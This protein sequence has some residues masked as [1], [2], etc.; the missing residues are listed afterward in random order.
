MTQIS[1]EAGQV[2]QRFDSAQTDLGATKR[3]LFSAI[4]LMVLALAIAF[5]VAHTF[6]PGLVSFDSWRQYAQVIKQD[7]LND[8]HPVIMVYVWRFLMEVIG[9]PGV[10]LGFHQLLYW[11]G[12]AALACLTFRTGWTRLAVFL[13]IGFC[14]PLFILTLHVWKDVG[15]LVGLLWASVGLLAFARAQGRRRCERISIAVALAGMFYATAVR[16]NGFAP[17]IFLSAALAALM[18]VPNVRSFRRGM[19]LGAAMLALAAA[20]QSMAMTA[21]NADAKKVYALGTLMV[22]DMVEISLD[23]Q[24]DLVPPYLSRTVQSDF[25]GE[26]EKVRSREANYKSF[27]IV[28][29]YPPAEYETQLTADWFA[30]VRKYPGSYLRHRLHVIGVLLGLQPGPI[31]YPFHRGIDENPVGL[32]FKYM[33]DAE[34]S[35]WIARF[36]R[37]SKSLLYRPWIYAL[38]AVVVFVWGGLRL[39]RRRGA[40]SLNLI[41]VAVA[42]S[43]LANV[44]AL[45]FLATAAD[46]RYITW[47]LMAALTS[48][49]ILAAGLWDGR[50]ATVDRMLASWRASIGAAIL[51][52]PAHPASRG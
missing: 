44:A 21:L 31:Y 47:L 8:A 35:G 20:A 2:A 50:S 17:T 42:A 18:L 29:P 15:M 43:G 41:A 4:F 39:V 3:N 24:T 9:D 30:L 37:A 49:V 38:L 33:S 1:S 5:V 19:F 12:I 7:P 48:A 10:M 6:S 45:T 28:S 52:R 14:P 26:L 46:Y 51:G 32:K 22:W 16:L 25:L 27:R 13:G 34:L 36:D 23:R 40:F 11:T